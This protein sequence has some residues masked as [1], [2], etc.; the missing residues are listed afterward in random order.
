MRNLLRTGLVAIAL[1]FYW[2]GPVRAQEASEALHEGFLHPPDDAR[3]MMRWWWF[4]P[5]VTKPELQKELET[6]KTA[7]IGGGEIQPVYPL[8][9][10]DA[11]EGVRNL[12]DL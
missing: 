2:T 8:E 6:M 7:G 11:A 10:D 3:P 4:G 5:A 9:L 12:G 1:L